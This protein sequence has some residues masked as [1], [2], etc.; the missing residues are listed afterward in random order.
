LSNS[1]TVGFERYLSS[2]VLE[3]VQE[4]DYRTSFQV[5]AS[6][7]GTNVQVSSNVQG[8]NEPS[9]AID[10]SHP[11]RLVVGTNDMSPGF[12]WLGS[13][14]S[15][16]GGLTWT[17]GAVPHTNLTSF[18]YAS[19]PSV[20]FDKKG[21]LYY[22][23]VAFNAISGQAVDGSVFVSRSMDGGAS[24]NRTVIVAQGLLTNKINVFNDKPYVAVDTSNGADE[25]RVY[26]SWTRFTSSRLTSIADIMVAYSAN[27][28][29]SFSTPTKIS[30]STENQ[31]SI[32]IVDPSG[33]LYVVWGDI[34]SSTIEAAKSSNGGLSFS[35]P[36]TVSSYVG[37]PSPLPNSLFRT[38]SFP[39]ASAD[40][41]NG[42][43]YVAWA[44][45]RNGH[46]DVL[47][48]RTTDG[49]SSWNS[50]IKVNDDITSNDH[51]FPWMSVSSGHLTI[52]FYD[53]RLDPANVMIDVFQ[54]TSANGG[55]SFSPNVRVTD[56]S[57]NPGT[58]D[59]IGDYIGIASNATSSHPVWADLRNISALTPQDE[60]I[61][62]DNKV[63]D[64]PPAIDPI[65]NQTVDEG[66]QLSFQARATDPDMAEVLTLNVLA[67]PLGASFQSRSSATGTVT[68][69]FDWTPVEGQGN[70][71]YT[72]KLVAS[73]GFFV[74]S[75]N[76]TVHVNDVNL[77]PVISVSSGVSVLET[78]RITFKVTAIDP[79]IPPETILFSCDKCSAIGASFDTTSGNFTWIP[80][81]GQFGD[82]NITFTA[83]DNG[84]PPQSASK[85]VL[86]HVLDV[87]FPPSLTPV[88][89]QRVEDGTLLTF[90][91][92]AS[93][94]DIPKEPLT[95][96]LA[97]D[98]PAGA[99]IS[100]NGVFAWTPY[101]SQGSNVYQLTIIVS[102][103]SLTVSETV[104]ITVIETINPPI[105]TVPSPQTVEAGSL[106]IFTVN[107]TYPDPDDA[108]QFIGLVKIS[109]TGLPP[110]A[111][112][113]NDTG[114]LD[115]TPSNAQ[116]PGV[117]KVI[118]TATGPD[119]LSDTKS[120]TI[121]VTASVQPNAPFTGMLVALIPWVVAI[122][123]ILILIFGTLLRI[124]KRK[125]G[126]P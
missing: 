46:S 61:F 41:T 52:A 3:A 104:S 122:A 65:S 105:L 66:R 45:Y 92:L 100:S 63:V 12:A 86:V 88:Q 115:W 98:A 54:A 31:G 67:L 85:F 97:P 58:V 15:P 13:Y 40:D 49:G 71:N 18:S 7:A 89:D 110:G 82:Y 47:F 37:I 72:M 117:Y 106:L 20:L 103:G 59:F 35:A 1:L 124:M 111:N 22:G 9:V 56:T 38:N 51:F 70:A 87:N 83:A 42:N 73:D 78:S 107:S 119:G 68:G 74:R 109:A 121:N 32:P 21:A 60:N 55:I 26:L 8:Q 27:G 30:G 112:F 93:D 39:T 94:P 11:Q 90:N 29:A 96:T 75:E 34:S 91:V 81:E 4:M 10:P 69:I 28:G 95:F 57:S 19:D 24:Y 53:R 16:D 62:T 126:S 80:A 118:F 2:G 23:G 125:K 120:V 76:V 64:R 25:G 114:T 99:T 33:E 5:I 48:T 14:A 43:V 77:A 116:A 84:I 101:E 44:D 108:G 79:D 36:T 17:A 113:D 102:D 123:A 50:L 6:T